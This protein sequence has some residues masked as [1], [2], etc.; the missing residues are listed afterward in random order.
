MKMVA[1]WVSCPLG[2]SDMDIMID[3][4]TGVLL[5]GLEVSSV[6]QCLIF[7]F[8]STIWHSRTGMARQPHG[9]CGLGSNVC[10]SQMTYALLLGLITRLCIPEWLQH[11]T[12]LAFS[13]AWL[14]FMALTKAE[15]NQPPAVCSLQQ[16]GSMY[17]T[18]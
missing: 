15:W 5:R 11:L 3:E 9:C 7:T 1:R 14:Q 13:A 8:A 6:Q 2:P 18:T 10:H 12:S 17:A 16:P 4:E